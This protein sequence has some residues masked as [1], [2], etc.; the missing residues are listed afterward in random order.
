MPGLGIGIGIG[1]TA[2]VGMGVGGVTRPVVNNISGNFFDTA[3]WFS[4]DSHAI[5]LEAMSVEDFLIENPSAIIP[6]GH[7]EA[8]GVLKISVTATSVGAFVMTCRYPAS[9][10]FSTLKNITTRMYMPP[11]MADRWESITSGNTL[12]FIWHAGGWNNWDHY[13]TKSVNYRPGDWDVG[14]Q[15]GNCRNVIVP[16]RWTSSA[17]LQKTLSNITAVGGTPDSR[18]LEWIEMYVRGDAAAAAENPLVIY[19]LDISEIYEPLPKLYF[20][21]DDST[22]DHRAVSQHMRAGTKFGGGSLATPLPATFCLIP[23]TIDVENFLSLSDLRVM[24][25]EGSTLGVHGTGW[26]WSNNSDAQIEAEISGMRAVFTSE[27]WPATWGQTVTFPG[28]DNFRESTNGTRIIDLAAAEGMKLNTGHS[29]F[30]YG[31]AMG[32]MDD[33]L[34]GPS[35]ITLGNSSATA[36]GNA[37]DAETLMAHMAASGLSMVLMGHRVGTTGENDVSEATFDEVMSAFATE[38]ASGTPRIG[39]A[40]LIADA[41]AAGVFD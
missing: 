16:T 13:Y 23:S 5:T 40:D 15:P 6:P 29:H 8:N 21:F 27:G 26:S 28:N 35:I 1:I 10:A 2:G 4:T 17:G 9:R 41:E 12:Q 18:D 19:I 22:A 14:M 11:A 31:F 34:A 38:I 33:P 37:T 39:T 25:A 20:R 3:S 7:I 24:V 30:G 36:V 32:A